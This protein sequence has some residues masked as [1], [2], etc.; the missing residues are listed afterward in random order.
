[1]TKN[2][3]TIVK[4][5]GNRSYDFFKCL[6]IRR[7][8][9]IEEQ[10]VPEEIEADEHDEHSHHYLI[11]T[12][13][14]SIATARWRNTEK[15]IKLERFAVLSTYR[16][17]GY[18]QLILNEILNDIVPLKKTIYLHSQ[19]TAVNFYLK[20]NFV[21]E[22]EAFYEANIKHFKMIFLHTNHLKDK[23]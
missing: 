22:G 6:Q 2:N 5:F 20:N 19:D 8:V 15:G 21:I 14:I 3:I 23:I 18:G 17:K 13:N 4:I 12:N 1:M 11:T 16:N 10:N 7:K 9:F